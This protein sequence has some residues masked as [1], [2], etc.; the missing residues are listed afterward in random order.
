MYLHLLGVLRQNVHPHSI[1]TTYSAQLPVLTRSHLDYW[2]R[3]WSPHCT[4][5]IIVLEHVQKGKAA[6]KGLGE[7][8]LCGTT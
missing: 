2:V 7:Q 3:F 5:N 4:E 6:V 1:H 8:V